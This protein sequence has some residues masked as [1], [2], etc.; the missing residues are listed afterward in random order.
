MIKAGLLPTITRLSRI[1]QMSA[2]L[3]DNIFISSNLYKN[4]DSA[5]LLED[6]SD[7]LPVMALLK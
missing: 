1:T 2:T 6:I 4:F 5:L 7:H 3:I